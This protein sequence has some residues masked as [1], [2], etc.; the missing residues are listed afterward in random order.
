MPGLITAL[1]VAK[2]DRV[3]TGDVLVVMEAMK[4]VHNLVAE[5][6][7]IVEAIHCSQG[8]TVPHKSPLVEIGPEDEPKG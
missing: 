2:G 1:S 5:A 6:D 8:D 7:G 4:L 3:K